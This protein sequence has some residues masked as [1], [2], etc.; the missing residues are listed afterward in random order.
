MS[1]PDTPFISK[2]TIAT[3]R[4]NRHPENKNTPPDTTESLIVKSTPME[5]VVLSTPM[6]MDVDLVPHDDGRTPVSQHQPR[7][8]KQGLIFRSFNLQNTPRPGFRALRRGMFTPS[9]IHHLPS[10]R[11]RSAPLF[12][13]RPLAPSR[14]SLSGSSSHLTGASNPS[15][16]VAPIS[17]F[18][19][20][21]SP[22]ALQKHA[23]AKGL[24]DRR[25]R[26]GELEQASSRKPQKLDPEAAQLPGCAQTEQDEELEKLHGK[27]I[28]YLKSLM[29]PN[30]DA[31]IFAVMAAA[32][33]SAAAS[34]LQKSISRA[35]PG[36]TK[37]A[38]SIL[39]QLYD[40]NESGAK[41]L[42]SGQ[43]PF[44]DIMV[45][46]SPL[47]TVLSHDLP[48]AMACVYYLL[49]TRYAQCWPSSHQYVSNQTSSSISTNIIMVRVAEGI[50]Y[51]AWISS[52]EDSLS[53]KE[54][55]ELESDLFTLVGETLEGQLKLR[56]SDK[57]EQLIYWRV[58]DNI[59]KLHINRPK[60]VY[61]ALSVLKVM[62]KVSRCLEIM[63]GWSLRGHTWSDDFSRLEILVRL[64]RI[65]G[66]DIKNKALDILQ[67]AVH[68]NKHQ[69]DRMVQNESLVQASGGL[70]ES[71]IHF[72]P[73][74]SKHQST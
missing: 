66:N 30:A 5:D 2:N 7:T 14:R 56:M 28:T 68:L 39:R 71:S 43:V 8:P 69:A 42:C 55:E 3:R 1:S 52:D 4:S 53:E 65:S 22:K 48:T 70:W 59:L 46:R 41:E 60:T 63:A 27:C 58:I 35:R 12:H 11:A 54:A 33:Q 67:K 29:T 44:L 16:V 9:S 61:R 36:Y 51:R 57:A 15:P 50:G 73:V 13:H 21:L 32:A 31:P 23:K 74:K 34:L 72:A 20:K 18:K 64:G 38:V 19:P 25:A 62:V 45:E 37:A 6:D 49:I 26:Q 10:L 17:A 47:E 40:W 24:D